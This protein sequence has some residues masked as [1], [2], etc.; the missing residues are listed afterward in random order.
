MLYARDVHTI[1]YNCDK[2]E[3]TYMYNNKGLMR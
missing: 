1:T 3:I 2:L